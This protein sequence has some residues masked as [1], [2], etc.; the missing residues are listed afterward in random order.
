MI[1]ETNLEVACRD[2]RWTLF[3][4]MWSEKLDKYLCRLHT[5]VVNCLGASSRRVSL[6]YGRPDRRQ[7]SRNYHRLHYR[8]LR[9]CY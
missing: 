5:N 8:H 2:Q 9:T 3:S 7:V 1:T 6:N 4:K